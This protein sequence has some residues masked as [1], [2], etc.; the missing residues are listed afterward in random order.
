MLRFFRKIRQKLLENGNLRK[1]FWYALGEILLVMVGILL[2]LQVNNWNEERKDALTET[3]YLKS[4]LQDLQT[5]VEALNGNI[6]NETI[7][8]E[9]AVGL[10]NAY[11]WD[12]KLNST[13]ENR[14]LM[15]SLWGRTTFVV[16]DPTFSELIATGNIQLISNEILRNQIIEYYQDFERVELIIQKNNDMKDQSIMP[17]VFKYV[18]IWPEAAL[19]LQEN[20]LRVQNSARIDTIKYP[21]FLEF[22]EEILNR[23]EVVFEIL[24]MAKFKTMTH[25]IAINLLVDSKAEAQN[26][27]KNIKAQL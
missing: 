23:E 17:S 18:D 6:A 5:Q 14:E 15:A 21:S 4:L 16:H 24:N 19:K 2:A 7:H 25:S 20:S 27:I 12:G 22:G 1:Y 3:Q 26:L 9:R 10:I 13:E 11:N 8:F